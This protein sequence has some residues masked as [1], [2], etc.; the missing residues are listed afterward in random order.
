MPHFIWQ[1]APSGH[2]ALAGVS[3]HAQSLVFA[4][5]FPIIFSQSLMP[6]AMSSPGAEA[7]TWCAGMVTAAHAE[8]MG[9]NAND[10]AISSARM[11][12][13]QRREGVPF[14]RSV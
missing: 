5:A 1:A 14:R 4:G 13:R 2:G 6:A 9:V 11:G 3:Q 8:T 7:A 10:S 12:R